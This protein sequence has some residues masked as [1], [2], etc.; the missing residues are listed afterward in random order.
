[1]VVENE[2]EALALEGAF[3]GTWSWFRTTWYDV[4]GGWGEIDRDVMNRLPAE[5]MGK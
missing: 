5:K 1:V 4:G 2:E 3:V